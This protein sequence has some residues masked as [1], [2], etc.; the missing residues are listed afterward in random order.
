M[1]DE[2]LK[3]KRYAPIIPIKWAFIIIII[4]V[5]LFSWKQHFLTPWVLLPFIVALIVLNLYRISRQ[6]QQKLQRI[7]EIKIPSF[8]LQRFKQLYPQIGLKQQRLIEQGFKDY[9]SLHVLNKQAY[10]MPSVAVDML[11]HVMLEYPE[12]YKQFCQQTLGRDLTHHPYSD[13]D[14][15]PPEKQRQQLIGSWRASC[16]LQ[17][18]NPRNT[19]AL[20]RLFAIDLAL[21]WPDGQL[22]DLSSLRNLYAN[23]LQD[24]SSSSSSCGGSSSSCSSDDGGS[25]CGGGCGGGGD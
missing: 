1:L 6:Q 15:P 2:L 13:A 7:D 14:A 11:W 24:S 8:F 19:S 5:L 9:L 18:L 16:Q 25:G 21:A 12:Q 23:S 17:K 10:A 3:Q 4:T 20:P 22:H